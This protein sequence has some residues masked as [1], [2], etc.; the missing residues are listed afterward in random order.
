MPRSFDISAEYTGTVELVHRTFADTQYWLAR[1]ADSG[2]DD[3]TL[4]SLDVGADGA[5]AVVTTQVLRWNRLPGVVTQFYKRDLQIGRR[6]TWTPITG[7]QTRATVT[8]HIPGAP[9]SLSGSAI[10]APG[11]SDRRCTSHLDFHGTVEVDVPLV[12]A[13]IESY[14]GNQLVDLLGAEQQFTTQWLSRNE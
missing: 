8:G 7:R 9:V 5:I 13:K 10:L 11:D 6:E 3:A 14:I 4:D 1:L 12:G 2:A